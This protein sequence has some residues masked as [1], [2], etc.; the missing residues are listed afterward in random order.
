MQASTCTV[1]WA[2]LG[3]GMRGTSPLVCQVQASAVLEVGPLLIIEE[4]EKRTWDQSRSMY[5]HAHAS[6][7]LIAFLESSSERLKG[8]HSRFW[9]LSHRWTVEREGICSWG[10]PSSAC[11]LRR[12]EAAPS[13]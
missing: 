2:F 3:V 11:S 4:S 13:P 7:A 5:F 8:P 12:K 9:L 1:K 10:R 6:R